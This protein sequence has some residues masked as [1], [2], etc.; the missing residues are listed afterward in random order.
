MAHIKK[1][2]HL[3]KLASSFNLGSADKYIIMA[4][5]SSYHYENPNSDKN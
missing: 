2:N 3:F 4:N 5:N 1:F